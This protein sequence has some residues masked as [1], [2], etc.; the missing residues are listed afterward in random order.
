[1][2]NVPEIMAGL[3]SI[4]EVLDFVNHSMDG[5]PSIRWSLFLAALEHGELKP[6]LDAVWHREDQELMAKAE[7][8]WEEKVRVATREFPTSI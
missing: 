2:P 6:M 7:V 5:G 4:D 1:M 3:R 8:I